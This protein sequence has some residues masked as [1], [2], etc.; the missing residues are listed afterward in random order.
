MVAWCLG[1]AWLPS[2][3]VLPTSRLSLQTRS[4]EGMREVQLTQ[5]L[6]ARPSAS[7]LYHARQVI[8]LVSP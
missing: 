7:C 8:H 5:T 1:L 2:C 6:V 4:S 3:P